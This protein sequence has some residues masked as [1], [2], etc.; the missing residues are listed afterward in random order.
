MANS[1]NVVIALD[2]IT[3]TDITDNYTVE[4][5][6]DSY[7]FTGDSPSGA[8]S[9]SCSV[10][11]R[12][13]KGGEE[14]KKQKT[15]DTIYPA[16]KS[17]TTSYSDTVI[18]AVINS[19]SGK[20]SGDTWTPYALDVNIKSGQTLTLAKE[21]PITA[22]IAF[23]SSAS[24][25][26]VLTKTFTVTTTKKGTDGSSVTITGTEIR[27][28]YSTSGTDYT[29]VT[30]WGASIP[31]VPL[32][33]YLWTRTKVTYNTGT[34]TTSYNVSYAAQNGTSQYTFI[35]Y[36]ADDDTTAEGAPMHDEPQEGDLCIGIVNVNTNTA[37]TTKSS[38][39]WSKYVGEDGEDGANGFSI[40]TTTAN[41]SSN[42]FNISDLHGPTG[43]TPRVNETIIR[44]NRYQYTITAVSD[45]KVTVGTAVDLKGSNGTSV[46]WKGDLASAPSNPQILWAY[47]NTTDKKSYIYNGSS[48][49]QMTTDGT[50]ATQY[51]YHVVYCNNTTSGDG[52]S[53]TA[54]N[55]IY[56]GTY[57]DTVQ[58]DAATWA[59]AQTKNVKWNYTKGDPGTD[60]YNVATVN[61]YKTAVSK[62]SKPY[63]NTSG[64]IT[65]TFST[66][67][68]SPT[69]TDSWSLSFPSVGTSNPIWISTINLT[70]QDSTIT[71]DKTKWSDPVILADEVKAI[72]L[73]ANP[74]T[75]TSVD[76]GNTY[77]PDSITITPRFQNTT[78]LTNGW[79]YINSGGTEVQLTDSALP[80]GF[81][82]NVTTKALTINKSLVS[83]LAS[84]SALFKNYKSIVF[85]CKVNEVDANN[86]NIYDTFTVVKLKDGKAIASIEIR[87]GAS[88]SSTTQPTTWY[89]D[90]DDVSLQPGYFLWTRYKYTYSDGTSDPYI[91]TK[92]L[93]GITGKSITSVT[94]LHYL[95]GPIH[96]GYKNGSNFYEDSA[97]TT[98][99]TPQAN[100]FYYDKTTG[101]NKYYKYVNSSY[102]LQGT[103]LKPQAPTSHVTETGEVINTWTIGI[104]HYV[105]GGKYYIC[106]EVAYDDTPTTYSWS[107]VILDNMV[108]DAYIEIDRQQ[109]EINIISERVVNLEQ[110]DEATA[111][112]IVL[113]QPAYVGSLHELH[114]APTANTGAGSIHCLYPRTDLYP[115]LT[116]YPRETILVVECS[117]STY[118]NKYQYHIDVGDLNYT[119]STIYDE[120]V[121]QD[122]KCW[123]I[124]RS[125]S[126]G[127]IVET[128]ELC[129][130]IKPV[131]KVIL[132]DG[133]EVTVPDDVIY[134]P[135]KTG[136]TLKLLGA[137]EVEAS[138][139]NF[140]YKVIYLTDNPYTSNFTSN[141]DL[142]SRINL[143]PG[144][145]KI[146]AR[147]IQLEGYTTIN[148]GFKIDLQGNMECQNANI[149]GSLVT[150]DGVLTNIMYRGDF[151]GGDQGFGGV[152]ESPKKY[153][154]KTGNTL[155]DIGFNTASDTSKWTFWY[156]FLNFP[157]LIPENFTP[158]TLRVIARADSVT[159][160]WSTN[161]NNW[162][163][164]TSG[165]ANVGLYKVS[166]LEQSNLLV[167][168]GDTDM[169]GCAP[170]FNQ[171]TSI[172]TYSF[173][174]GLSDNHVFEGSASEIF[175]DGPG[176]YNITLKTADSVPAD[177][178][179]GQ[180]KAADAANYLKTHLAVIN[181]T[182]EVIGYMQI[183]EEGGNN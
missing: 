104:P 146:Q 176:L 81:S 175:T 17:I 133:E 85:K 72:F 174:K 48:W 30:N 98:L 159:V 129:E 122:G 62:P 128:I 140:N 145:I 164:D 73:S 150:K 61:V 113:S 151:W 139:Y 37:P 94:P 38:Y 111:A 34:T 11:I 26:V 64:D 52:Y 13:F 24:D 66:N 25:D 32:G 182:C 99:I 100:H 58:T 68:F 20:W 152:W 89:E 169:T 132:I 57:T 178:S 161:G 49:D 91:Y 119:S 136:V 183:T 54:S 44:S 112:T 95:V 148:E 141:L 93:Q 28:G 154:M 1:Q 108:T 80:S 71:I 110:T 157:V 23:S 15:G 12:V 158:I 116:L 59:I 107:A 27:Y 165:C 143:A 77:S 105:E 22:T 172:P 50:D 126:G 10:D 51:Y 168:G 63:V 3:L 156:D 43:V 87:Y 109:G 33:Q 65:Y 162:Y 153:L 179:G 79:S 47:Y 31:T 106:E 118:G 135:T 173:P 40:W 147:N 88:A 103:D 56:T 86:N 35:R 90:I 123:I 144:N 166:N 74:Q 160:G 14:L 181:A 101:Q 149:N 180:A 120:F 97:H 131:N 84:G 125:S 6:K 155:N 163:E 5:S 167:V 70:S 127:D 19:N 4:L 67:T 121:Y 16:L 60:G 82:L 21:I 2:Q 134:I 39:V 171:I 170:T 130:N 53:T 75:F 46:E 29:T 8:S 45:T 9:G 117:D 102:S 177:I 7:V 142:I 124:R 36:S 92:A 69:L 41:P 76:G 115:S 78:Y 96:E 18:N 55:Q 42:Q 137:N 114:I 83:D 138:N